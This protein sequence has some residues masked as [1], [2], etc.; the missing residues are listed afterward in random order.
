MNRLG[1]RGRIAVFFVLAMAL[2]LAGMGG[3]AYVVVGHE[4][5]SA[6]DL[7]LRRQSTRIVRQ[8]PVEPSVAA[9]SGACEYVAAPSCV[10]VVAADGTIE[11]EH[12]PGFSLP[13]DTE[14]R[15]LAAGSGGPFFSDITLDGHRMRMYTAPLRPGSVVQVAQRSETVDTGLRRVGVALVVAAIGGTLLAAAIGTL[16]ARRALAPVSALTLAAERVAR[17]RDPHAH[18]TVTGNDELARL[19]TSVNTMLAE[20]DAALTSERDSRAAQQR[21]VADASHELRTPLTALRTNIDLLR[22]GTRLSPAQLTATVAALR[23][24]SEE[25]SGLVTDVIDL[26]RADDPAAQRE[27]PE[28]L[29]LDT[30]VTERLEVARRHWPAIT[31][32]AELTPTTIEGVPARLARAVTNLLDNAAKFSPSDGIVRVTVRDRRLTVGDDGPGIAAADVPHV[33]DRFYRAG[34]ARATPG[35]GLGL[36]IVAQVAKAHRAEITVESEPGRGA[37]FTL[38]FPS[39]QDDSIGWSPE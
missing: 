21:L 27:T 35:H 4:L 32:S 14:T 31:F 28:D 6:L 37:E 26:A 2:A 16:L 5:N 8:F 12:I 13:I 3:A 7:N 30:L 25:L 22:R 38:A 15:L 18:I 36:A 1:L 29:R 24:Q 9:M 34:T 20:L 23:V 10:Q 39:D 19:A 11:S 17:T 33:F